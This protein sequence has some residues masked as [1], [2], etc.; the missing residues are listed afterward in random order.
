MK[1]LQGIVRVG[2]LGAI[3]LTQTGAMPQREPYVANSYLHAQHLVDVG[4]R[5][6]NIICAGT[7]SP[8]VILDAGLAADATSWRLVQP[9]I[10]RHTRVCSYDRAGMGFSDPTTSSRDAAA[11]VGDLHA[12][13]TGAGISPPYV[14][15]GWSIAGLYSRLYVDRYPND[16]SGLVQVDPSSE[17]D[18]DDA[19]KIVPHRDSLIKHR[20]KQFRGC[21][22]N[23]SQ[24]TCAFF[25]GGLANYR[26]AL[27]AAGCPHVDPQD[28]AVAE[29][30]GEH[31]ARGS[32]WRD[33]ALESEAITRSS[34]E[35]R[36]NQR[37]YG[38]LPLIILTDSEEGD[39]DHVPDAPS[40]ALQHAVW[41]A[42]EKEHE[43]IAKL[44]SVGAHFVVAGS[45]HAI[46]LDHPST[47]VSAVD[48]VV[49]QARYNGSRR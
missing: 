13:L 7:G 27:R 49:D 35:V 40:V 17:N 19:S 1:S 22:V 46:Q 15:V 18:D 26:K 37:P 25:P 36:V 41:A 5:R 42:K 10:A 28:C 4:G 2:V 11:I 31:E 9:A 24:G 34:S 20:D 38:N 32:Y 44:S 12:L 43:R 45:M 30:V 3:L 23:I 6:L 16:V 8:A 29:V 47:V 14:L 33:V 21:A 39:I 48:E